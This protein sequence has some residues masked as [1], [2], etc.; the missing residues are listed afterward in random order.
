MIRRYFKKLI[1]IPFPFV[2]IVLSHPILT[3]P[4]N[5]SPE[6]RYGPKS[7]GAFVII[8]P[9]AHDGLLTEYDRG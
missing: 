2:L 5:S 8:R 9:E 3:H 4:E 1:L 6:S 7:F